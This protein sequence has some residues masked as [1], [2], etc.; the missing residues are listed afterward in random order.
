MAHLQ[1]VHFKINVEIDGILLSFSK[2]FSI[3]A[4]EN[5]GII[6]ETSIFHKM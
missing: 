6:S 2:L 3:Q 4:K 1:I 5:R